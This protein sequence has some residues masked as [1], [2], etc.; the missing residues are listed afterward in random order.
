MK[1]TI[2]ALLSAILLVSVSQAGFVAAEKYIFSPVAESSENEHASK[3]FWY[4]TFELIQAAEVD[5]K[6]QLEDVLIQRSTSKGTTKYMLKIELGSNADADMQ[7]EFNPVEAAW[8]LVTPAKGALEGALFTPSSEE[9]VAIFQCV[10]RGEGKRLTM[11]LSPQG[12]HLAKWQIV[13][14]I[15]G[16]GNFWNQCDAAA[17]AL[18]TD[19]PRE[20]STCYQYCKAWTQGADGGAEFR[21][22]DALQL[23][24]CPQAPVLNKFKYHTF[25]Y[26]EVISTNKSGT[27]TTNRVEITYMTNHLYKGEVGGDWNIRYSSSTNAQGKVTPGVLQASKPECEEKWSDIIRPNHSFVNEDLANAMRPWALNQGPW[28]GFG[29]ACIIAPHY[30]IASSHYTKNFY[31]WC[32]SRT[33]G[34]IVDG[35]DTGKFFYRCPAPN[36][37]TGTGNH[38]VIAALDSDLSVIYFQEAFP[39]NM[40][41]KFV[42]PVMWR[43]ISGSRLHGALGIAMTG[44]NTVFPVEMTQDIFGSHDNNHGGWKYC[45]GWKNEHGELPNLEW[46]PHGLYSI[47]QNEPLLDGAGWAEHHK[48]LPFNDLVHFGHVGDSSRPCGFWTGKCF[49]PMGLNWQLPMVNMLQYV[50]LYTGACLQN[51]EVQT[52]IRVAIEQDSLDRTGEKETITYFTREELLEK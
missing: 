50:G 36:S 32:E 39:S 11:P 24:W 21:I 20:P 43:S 35:K 48:D 6:Q 41:Q 16:E 42:N 2:A 51:E 37:A 4:P 15:S 31:V 10:Y 9:G 1:Q 8:E 12:G 13:G 40:I 46:R 52:Q 19:L 22:P 38:G 45:A 30:A 5:G 25:E 33:G 7:S 23:Y 28:Y 47:P 26:N 27:V 44:H 49:I 18:F 17:I 3:T 14:G 29:L 34:E